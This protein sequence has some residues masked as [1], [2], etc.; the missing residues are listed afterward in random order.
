MPSEPQ[1]LWERSI[2]WLLRHQVVS[3]VFAA[4]LVLAGLMV[5]PFELPTG[6]LPRD[7]VPV[8]ALPDIGDNQQIVFTT[9][10][11]RS[12]RDVEDQLTYPLTT[13][14]QGLPGVSTVRSSSALG[15][16][17]I[18]VIFDDEVDFYWARTRV[19]E[20]LS[21]LPPGPVP[22]GGQPTLGPDARGGPPT[23]RWWEGGTPTSCAAS[24]TG[25]CATRCSRSRE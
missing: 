16:S 21:A 15:F 12:P 10:P 9:W 3:F 18:Y 11:G 8:D 20:K 19:L 22:D 17:S 24:R 5:S 13:A 14:L 1:G 2:G 6:P 23:A 25:Q 4:L 7:P